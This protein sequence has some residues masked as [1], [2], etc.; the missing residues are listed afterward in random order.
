MLLFL[1]FWERQKNVRWFMDQYTEA[2]AKYPRAEMGF[3]G[4]SNGTYLLASALKRYQASQFG[5]VVFAGSVVP[6]A[7]PWDPLIERKRLKAI[8][9]YVA[10]SDIIVGVFP[11]F[12]ELIG[13]TDLGSAGHNGFRDNEGKKNAVTFVRG[14]HGAALRP[15][16]YESLIRFVIDGK[17]VDIP[18]SLMAKKRSSITVWLSKFNWIVWL[19]LA[20]GLLSG[21]WLIAQIDP[22][23]L[24]LYLSGLYALLYT[25]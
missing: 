7:F 2:L 12:Y 19:L 15:E 3:I 5:R 9:N 21:V 16:I 8:Q 6:T 20:S 14:G 11:G 18:E 24:L 17:F 4:H 22:V 10:T 1:F 13:L 25:T 23:Y